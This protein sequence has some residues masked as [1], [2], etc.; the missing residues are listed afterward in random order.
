MRQIYD[1]I[2]VGGGPAGL[3]TAINI[4]KNK[5]VL[6]IE[7]KDRLGQKIL[8]T[9]NGKCNITNDMLSSKYY[10]EDGVTRYFEKYNNIQTV[11]DFSKMGLETYSDDEGR[12]FPLSNS[13]VSVLDI[14]LKQVELR[15]NIEICVDTDIRNI[16]NVDNLFKISCNN[17]VVYG[18]K[19]VIAVGSCDVD[20]ILQQ[21][22]VRYNAF[23]PSLVSLKSEKNKGLA[24]VRVSNVEVRFS[25]FV[26]RGEV[27]FKEDGISGIV[28]FNLSANF[29]RNNIKKGTVY[30]DLLP[31]IAES[32]LA[33]I[34]SKSLTNNP[35]YP[36]TLLLEGFMHKALAKNIESK[37]FDKNVLAKDLNRKD[38]V[39]LSKMIKNY[40][41]NIVG[42]SDNNQVNSGGVPI[43]CLTENL[44]YKNI[45]GLYFVGEVVDIDGVCGGY[46]LQ[47]AWTSGK[48]VGESI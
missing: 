36:L 21:L 10:N 23:V 42:L 27:L 34:I 7:K 37:L 14:L 1:C 16:T 32:E 48:I 15:Q 11:S 44:M 29:A 5:N 6:I 43:E 40:M 20:N 30:I 41:V 28:V 8:V 38:I 46:N 2:V 19:V 13:A 47:W 12:R 35:N 22:G 45:E 24:G 18:K 26:E 33:S 3:Y 9:G 4:S 39:K 17:M 25:N 31:D